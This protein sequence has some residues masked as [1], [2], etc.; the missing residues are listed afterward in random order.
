MSGIIKGGL[1]R[2]IDQSRLGFT[3]LEILVV[4]ALVGIL[5]AIAS[6]AWVGFSVN[7]SLNAAQSRAFSNLRSAQSSAKRD[8]VDWQASFRNFGDRAQY[9]VHKT[10]ISYTNESA[11]WN[12]LPWEN[13]DSAIK[14]V[15]NAASGLPDT[16]FSRQSPRPV[17]DVYRVRFTYKGN[18]DGIGEQGKITFAPKVGDRRK[19]VIVSTLLGAMRL[20]EGS[21]CN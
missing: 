13:F 3:L 4:L 2:R 12:N 18:P 20:A 10:P 5:G 21:A 17:P 8:Q 14:I 15:E 9:A 16:T 1:Y 6:P 11:Y 19:C 7:Q